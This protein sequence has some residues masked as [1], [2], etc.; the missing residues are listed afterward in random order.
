VYQDTL[1]FGRVAHPWSWLIF[2]VGSVAALTLGYR[3]FRSVKIFIADV[4]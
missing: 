4:L 3:A 1:Y 2:A